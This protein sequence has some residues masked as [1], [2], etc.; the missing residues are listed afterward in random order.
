MVWRHVV[1]AEPSWRPAAAPP[2][3][4]HAAAAETTVTVPCA[5]GPPVE[6][7]HRSLVTERARSFDEE[8]GVLLLGASVHGKRHIAPRHEHSD[9]AN[10]V[11]M[12]A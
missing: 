4:A 7:V 9:G 10:G 1:A 11:R 2:R 12:S 5:D 6:R 3:E 8:H